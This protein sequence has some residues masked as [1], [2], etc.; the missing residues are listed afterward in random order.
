MREN[1]YFFCD[2]NWIERKVLAWEQHLRTLGIT[3]I[4][5]IARG[6][7]V[8]ATMLCFALDLPKIH[9]LNVDRAHNRLEEQYHR[10][11]TPQSVVLLC[12]D[13][14][15]DGQTL[16]RCVQHLKQQ[17][18]KVYTLTIHH[19]DGSTM[20]PD[21][22]DDFG[23]RIGI[24]PWER[25]RV[26]PKMID[27]YREHRR[28]SKSD[29]AYYRYGC[30]LDGVFLP[31]IDEAIY[32]HH[33]EDALAMRAH[34]LPYPANVLPPIDMSRAMII[35]GRPHCD[36][37]VTEQWLVT[38]Q[39]AY[40]KLL[41]RDPEMYA[42]QPYD[43][44]A[45]KAQQAA[46]MKIFWIKEQHITHFFESDPLQATLIARALPYV[47]VMWWNNVTHDRY[48]VSVEAYSAS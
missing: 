8:P 22:S 33:L 41:M 35:T 27:E 45:H 31:D 47:R 18:G 26:N 6:G 19:F 46:N 37:E 3:D 15:G 17:A 10:P 16:V 5:A 48:V 34:L 42:I 36:R 21:F 2:Y 9:I 44:P 12:E 7:I 28:L 30:D 25:F 38:H 24:F 11:L 23:H 4:V 20:R 32:Q 40:Q 1:D 14:A 39:I 43:D 29:S 13:V